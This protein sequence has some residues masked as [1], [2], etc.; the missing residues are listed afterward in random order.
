MASLG[1]RQVTRDLKACRDNCSV[2]VTELAQL[3]Q[4]DLRTG[5]WGRDFINPVTYSSPIALESSVNLHTQ[6]IL[7]HLADR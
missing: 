3:E 1:R 7:K 6:C 5:H 4:V 2:E